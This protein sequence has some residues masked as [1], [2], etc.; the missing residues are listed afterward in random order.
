MTQ[1]DYEASLVYYFLDDSIH[2]HLRIAKQRTIPALRAEFP[3]LH[4]RHSTDEHQPGRGHRIHGAHPQSGEPAG[5]RLLG[6]EEVCVLRRLVQL[7]DRQAEIG[8]IRQGEPTH[9]T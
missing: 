4:P 8:R 9:G 7:S 5:R 2:L 1:K 3:R 6:Q